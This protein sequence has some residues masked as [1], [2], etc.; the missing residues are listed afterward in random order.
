VGT[1]RA[2][3]LRDPPRRH[4]VMRGGMMGS[5]RILFSLAA[6]SALVL[7]AEDKKPAEATVTVSAEAQPVEV[8]RTPAPVRIVEAEE[9]AR[10][11]SRTLSELLEVLQPERGGTAGWAA[12]Q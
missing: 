7:S 12:P 3:I 11:G 10:L 4:D 8:T 2:K 5:S 6:L 1:G 9:L